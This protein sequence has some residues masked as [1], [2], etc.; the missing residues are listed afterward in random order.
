MIQGHYGEVA[1]VITAVCWTITAVAFESAGRRIGSLS[2]NIIRLVIAFVLIGLYTSFSRGMF[3]PLD[4]TREAWIWLTLSGMVGFV[5]GDLFLFQA[6]VE[7]GSR[8]S[9]LIM[10][11]VP[12]ITAL[13]SFILMGE[14][15]TLM[16]LLGMFITI[17]GIALV[18]LVRGT[19]EE[20]KV[21]LS[22]PIKGLFYAFI[23]AL[24]QAFGL[25]LSKYGMG[26][27]NAFAATQIRIIAGIIG[28]AV[29]VTFA[30]S[31]G[32]I[33]ESFKDFTAMR[34]TTI[35]AFFGPFLGVSF[36]LLAVQYTTTGVAS[37]IMSINRILII[38][39][40]ILVFKEKV[41]M[42]E[43]IGALITVA[44]VSLLFM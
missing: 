6:Y 37:T 18:I 11:T 40:S 16:D 36:S 42:K 7:I 15:L 33:Y 12:P 28:F 43:I 17:G 9:M 24:G 35:G 22:H 5:I 10:A 38:P 19:T 41:S 26:D 39:V 31:W 44:G 23:G 20:K 2:V 25:I 14:T 21:E 32:K 34:N 1:S 13:T 27:Y 8:I 29:V 3:L 30:K 4:A